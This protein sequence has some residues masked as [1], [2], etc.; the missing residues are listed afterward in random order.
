[1]S[2]YLSTD[3]TP[4]ICQHFCGYCEELISEDWAKL[5]GNLSF[6]NVL[7]LI[8]SLE[9][10]QSSL[11]ASNSQ[12]NSESDSPNEI[13][14]GRTFLNERFPIN[15]AQSSEISSSQYP[16]KCWQISGVRSVDKYIDN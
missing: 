9:N 3:R 16:Q 4:E 14:K 6:K 10:S 13:I 12:S 7:P 11:P 8:I 15:F 2:I 5:M 1:L